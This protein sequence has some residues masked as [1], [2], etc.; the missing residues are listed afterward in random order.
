MLV[1]PPAPLKASHGAIFFLCV[2]LVHQMEKLELPSGSLGD[3]SVKREMGGESKRE[4]KDV[5]LEEFRT[6]P[7]NRNLECL[8]SGMKFSS[9]AAGPR[10]GSLNTRLCLVSVCEF[11]S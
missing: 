7:I 3:G 9:L 4:G 2:S 5:S 8:W 6:N 1:L 11:A 10:T